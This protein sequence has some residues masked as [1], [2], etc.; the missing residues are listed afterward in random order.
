MMMNASVHEILMVTAWAIS[1]T[2]ETTE[3]I[4]EFHVGIEPLA[5]AVG[6]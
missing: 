3:R 2:T 1:G 6:Y 4:L 5:S